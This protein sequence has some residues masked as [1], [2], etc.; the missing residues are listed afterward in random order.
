MFNAVK[1]LYIASYGDDEWHAEM[2]E[3]AQL[4]WMVC[5]RNEDGSLKHYV[6]FDER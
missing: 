5:E 2:N 6:M 1:E 3:Q 4:A